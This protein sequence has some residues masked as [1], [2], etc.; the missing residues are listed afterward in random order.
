MTEEEI[1]EWK[2]EDPEDFLSYLDYC[3]EWFEIT[4]EMTEF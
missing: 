4:E 1:S 3:D 2:N